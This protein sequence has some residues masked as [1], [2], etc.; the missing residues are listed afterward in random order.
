[1]QAE[2]AKKFLSPTLKNLGGKLIYEID[3]AMGADDIPTFNMGHSMFKSPEVQ[4][5]ISDILEI[6]DRMV[7]S[8][9]H[10]GEYYQSKYNVPV[11]KIIV[12]PNLLP[13]S[14]MADK[15]IPSMKQMQ[16]QSFKSRP[17]VGI[18][19]SSCHWNI[20]GKKDQDGQ[21]IKDDISTIE[22]VI[23]DTIDEFMWVFIGQVP[24][25]IQDLVYS[26]KVQVIPGVSIW[27]YPSLL[28]KL[29][30]QMVV[31]PLQDIEFNRCKSNIKYLECS[32]L[33]IP[34]IAPDMLPYS[35]CVP[36]RFR[37]KHQDELLGILRYVK[38]MSSG[39]Y[40]KVIQ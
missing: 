1:M 3:D 31:A 2:F 19:S 32:A 25:S 18:I 39:A 40:T 35:T 24:N 12:M 14:W 33:G 5:S 34:L 16:F 13:V 22:Q 36:E 29:G 37:Y 9:E 8:T 17:R 26:K 20:E 7:V 28:F 27:Q 4:K 6:S 38:F 15:Y 30:L 10:L 21:L 23:R 11:E